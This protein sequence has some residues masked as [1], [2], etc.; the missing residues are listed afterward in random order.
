MPRFLADGARVTSCANN[1][2]EKQFEKNLRCTLDTIK[3]NS[4]LSGLS[5]NFLDDT[6]KDKS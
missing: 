5:F 6:Q 1:L 4:I 2:A 3:N